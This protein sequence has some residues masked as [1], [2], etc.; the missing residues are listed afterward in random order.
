MSNKAVILI[1]EDD[2]TIRNFMSA[3]LVAN[4]YGVVEA[5]NGFSAA[6]IAESHRPDLILLDL[7]LPDIDGIEV[8]KKLREWT[9]VPVVVV[10]AR[11]HEREKVEALDRGADD[12][13]TK[14]FGTEELLAR[15][16][17]SLR[18]RG[19]SAGLESGRM[20]VGE[21]EIDYEKRSVKLAGRE[22]HLTPVEYKIVVLM[23]RYAGKVLTP[24][25]ITK[26]IW[27]SDMNEVRAL[28]VNM[29]NIRRKLE[30]NPA[31]P[32]YIITEAGV[33]YKLADE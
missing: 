13:I 9:G 28:R 1:V 6:A 23:S 7:G 15:V 5:I 33:G 12:Y 17:A 31:D 30:Y 16:R 10:S 18:R 22:I 20:S 2:E 14:P 11:G 27:G 21:L 32:R 25:F 26:E 19:D 29:S 24:D 8:L 3:I 4:G